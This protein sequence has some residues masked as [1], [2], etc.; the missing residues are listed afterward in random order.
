MRLY[1]SF[2]GLKNFFLLYLET[3]PSLLSGKDCAY[4]LAERFPALSSVENFP[5]AFSLR[6]LDVTG[7]GLGA[8]SF[9]PLPYLIYTHDPVRY[10]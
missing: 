2:P 9:L 3:C 7:F 5:D 6:A 10:H 1:F 4:P 8:F